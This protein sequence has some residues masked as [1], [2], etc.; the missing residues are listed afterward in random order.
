MMSGSGFY[1]PSGEAA[2]F[3]LADIGR[4][5]AATYGRQ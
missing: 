1:Y 4:A 3:H 5:D 2:Q